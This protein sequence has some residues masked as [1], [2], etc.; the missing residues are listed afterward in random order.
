MSTHMAVRRTH[1][2]PGQINLSTELFAV[3]SGFPQNEWSRQ[4]QVETAAVSL[5]PSAVTGIISAIFCELCSFS[6]IHVGVGYTR[7]W[8]TGISR[9]WGAPL[10][11]DCRTYEGSSDVLNSH[12]SF[13]LVTREFSFVK[14]GLQMSRITWH[15]RGTKNT[16]SNN[17]CLKE[18]FFPQALPEVVIN[19]VKWLV[20]CWYQQFSW[21]VWRFPN[22]Q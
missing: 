7:V 8:L 19:R 17:L 11:V 4:R 6:P 5:W 15:L 12:S 13:F 21:H 22:K 10:G 20:I 16:L 1:F 14:S 9:Q 18:L 3:S 2:G